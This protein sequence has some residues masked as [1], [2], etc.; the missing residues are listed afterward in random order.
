M[1][2]TTA[3]S[4]QNHRGATISIKPS[5]TKNRWDSLGDVALSV[6]LSNNTAKTISIPF[7]DPR[8]AV[9]F[10]ITSKDNS[11]VKCQRDAKDGWESVPLLDIAPGKD[12]TFDAPLIKWGCAQSLTGT[13]KISAT[14]EIE[15]LSWPAASSETDQVASK[16]MTL[17]LP[18]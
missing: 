17:V 3:M 2:P 7:A 16:K 12:F 9:R 6:T 13:F 11:V 1:K 14:W 15:D 10:E 8:D 4:K 18:Q 5:A